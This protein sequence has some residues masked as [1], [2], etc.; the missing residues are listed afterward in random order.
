MNGLT[1]KVGVIGMIA[2]VAMLAAAPAANATETVEDPAVS[3]ESI[4]SNSH[5]YSLA[6]QGKPSGERI[7]IAIEG[8]DAPTE[9]QFRVQGADLVLPRD[10]GSLALLDVIDGDEV[11]LVGTIAK[12][13]ARDAAGATVPTH[14][15]VK[16]N[17]V[18]QVVEHRSGD[19]DYVITADPD[20]SKC[21]AGALAG[22][23]PGAGAAAAAGSVIP[24][25]GT[26]AGG[27]VG[28]LY[29][30]GAGCILAG[31]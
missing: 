13:W 30:A 2:V 26:M 15:T 23:L 24:F 25:W 3:I 18:T 19:Y 16:G 22:L 7:L 17:I 1:Q 21:A 4:T 14:F 31:G 5:G 11:V 27:V 10:D 29:G 9:Y 20:L 8:S 28:A 12:P 6:T